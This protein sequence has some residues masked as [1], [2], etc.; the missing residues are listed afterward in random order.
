MKL[1]IYIIS[2]NHFLLEK[3]SNEE[4]RRKILFDL[5]SKIKQ[6]GGSLIIGGDFFDFWVQFYS[7]TPKY[8][9]NI[10]DELEKLHKQNIEINY[11]LGNHDYWDFGF[12]KKK[13][14][15]ILHKKDFYF[16]VNKQKIMVTHGDG[17][18]KNDYMYRIMRVIIRNNLFMFFIRL[19]PKNMGCSIAK[20]IS[21]TK[22]KIG[23]SQD[24][25]SE[26]KNELRNFALQ[27]I[28]KEN[29]NAVLMGHYHQLG[30][31]NIENN[32]FIHLGDWINNRTVTILDENHKWIQ[33]N[34][35]KT[36]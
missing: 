22:K 18:L 19:L 10:L 5:F 13:F 12:F 4:N 3:S 29:I 33:Y 9:Q 36:Q 16:K 21:N 24:L 11:V 8:Y 23:R 15:A 1:P 7:G 34:M 20:Y 30:I 32:Y 17:L 14:G 6:T 25:P 27:K 26:Y 2:D 28:K 35:E 31:E